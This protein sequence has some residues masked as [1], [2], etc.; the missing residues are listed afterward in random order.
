M[1]CIIVS[2]PS[3]IT[4]SLYVSLSPDVVL[5]KPLTG[6]YQLLWKAKVWILYPS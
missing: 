6:H 4:A 2:L 5:R 1:E 3:V